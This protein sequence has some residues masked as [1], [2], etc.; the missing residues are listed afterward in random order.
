[1]RFRPL[2]AESIRDPVSWTAF[3][4]FG[5]RPTRSPSSVIRSDPM[6]AIGIPWLSPMSRKPRRTSGGNEI[7]SKGPGALSRSPSSPR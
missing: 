1:M 5:A 2:R 6:M 7:A 3:G 4:I